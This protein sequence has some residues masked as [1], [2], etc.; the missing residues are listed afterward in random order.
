[1]TWSNTNL[2]P[3][4]AAWYRTWDNTRHIPALLQY[5][6]YGLWFM[7]ALCQAK[8]SLWAITKESGVR[9][10]L[11]WKF[12]YKVP[13]T[14]HGEQKEQPLPV[15]VWY[16]QKLI[17]TSPTL[18]KWHLGGGGGRGDELGFWLEHFQF[19]DI[20]NLVDFFAYE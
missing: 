19:F 7:S 18:L 14:R 17:P 5:Q 9:T 13:N 2:T 20:E 3:I 15:P 16:V 1:M 8:I 12:F 10:R 6:Y 4:P 11:V